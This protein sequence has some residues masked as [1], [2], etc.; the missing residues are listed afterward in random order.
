M[1]NKVLGGGIIDGALGVNPDFSEVEAGLGRILTSVSA[2]GYLQYWIVEETQKA[3]GNLLANGLYANTTTLQEVG[4][5]TSQ[6]RQAIEA[7]Y[8]AQGYNNVFFF[9]DGFTYA[10][11]NDVGI[12]EDGTAW[13]YADAGALPV[14]VAAGTVPAN[15]PYK[16]VAY[17]TAAQ[18]STNTSDTVQSFIDNF[19]LKIFQSP[20][21]G[22]LTEIQ[23]RTVDANEVYEVR[24]TSDNSLATIYSDA[25][26]TTEVVQDGTS[27]VSSSD[28][29]VKFYIAD[30]D[31][32]VEVGGVKSNF[33]D[34][35]KATNV[36]T[37]DGK[38]VQDTHDAM[39][40]MLIAQ[41]LSGEYGFF[42]KG[43]DYV[44]VGDVGIDTDGKI[45]T[46]VGAASLPF[47]VA[48]GT[49]PVGS[50]DYNIE[51][52]N[53]VTAVSGEEELRDIYS[54]IIGMQVI[55]V[56]N[57]GVT[58][59][60]TLELLTDG[61][62]ILTAGGLH[63]NLVITEPR[64][65]YASQL[66]LDGGDNATS[67]LAG[68]LLQ[69]I[70][71]E[72]I[73][74]IVLDTGDLLV[75]GA[76]PYIYGGIT[77]SGGGRLLVNTL[78]NVLQSYVS[79]KTDSKKY[80]GKLNM[81]TVF[82]QASK[83]AIKRKEIRIVL[84]GDSISACADYDSVN[85][86]NGYRPLYGVDNYERNNCF[87]ASM[88]NEIVAAL[89]SDV[90]VRF[91]SR[92]I[93][94]RAYANIATAWDTLNPTVFSGREQADAGKAWRDCVIDLNPD[95]V[96]HSMGMNETPKTYIQGF[97]EQWIEFLKDEQ[98][99]NCFD[100]SIV[101][102]PNP[103]FT[104]AGVSG[105]FR[106]YNLNAN[107]I[108]VAQ[109]QRT[110][111]REHGYSL[112]DVAFNSNLKR[113][114]FDPRSTNF[115][116]V[117]KPLLY[118]DGSTAKAIQPA[119][120]ET[121]FQSDTPLFQS[122][123]FYVSGGASSDTAGFDFRFQ[124]GDALVQVAAG[125]ITIYP[126]GTLRVNNIIQAKS[127]AYVLPAQTQTKFTI[128][129]TPTSIYVYVNNTLTIH[130]ENV[131]FTATLPVR[132]NNNSNQFVTSVYNM[133]Y[134][135]SQFARYGQDSVTNGDYYGGLDF[136]S[137]INGGGVNHPSSTMLAEIYIPPVREFF[138]DLLNSNNEFSTVLGGTPANGAAFLG[139]I[140]M[141]PRNRVAIKEYF[142]GLEVIVT[143]NLDGVSYTVNSNNA[144]VDV[145]I[146]P[147][148]MSVFIKN[149]TEGI[150]GFELEGE[151][152]VKKP[153]NIGLVTP[154]GTVLSTV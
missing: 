104:D 72:S 41:G 149:T 76:L 64:K 58:H 18:V 9:E 26:G 115:T 121:L 128:T 103:N 20:T 37:S 133:K 59:L 90:R 91:Y 8:K 12:Y 28:G 15:P 105:D 62:G 48:A 123:V 117:E 22:G 145:Y 4:G 111:A 109:L 1:T 11:S 54:T 50:G 71:N 16:Q 79:Q 66:F 55:V 44:N 36:E 144:I 70:E 25:A 33:T 61:T 39:R 110:M 106:A 116:A 56:S 102:T 69:K 63:A 29:V 74:N 73:N 101:T 35:V 83:A 40:A 42:A 10:E 5:D 99:S 120:A 14:T 142:S 87:G 140:S 27:N 47:S 95:L 118:S 124:F 85:I 3:G 107:K 57:G 96:I 89:P 138:T 112:V 126:A 92:S 152:A 146:D 100:Q 84:L 38:S 129:L 132:A 75:T 65:I 53:N 86:P 98:R 127:V 81:G 80:H 46:Y 148:D 31:Y 137:N 150:Y 67:V 17:S 77:F 23:T 113:Y 131:Y 2:R 93:A 13:T 135:G 153:T 7:V 130:F 52:F 97:T 136:T 108:F 51:V 49:N 143:V 45:Y 151:W 147:D 134:F 21:D 78:D 114:G 19:A 122:T 154:R 125:L 34:I 30:G 32:Y 82:G 60:R 119:T 88:Y 24:K 141:I 68:S 43:F 94:G 139:R 6:L